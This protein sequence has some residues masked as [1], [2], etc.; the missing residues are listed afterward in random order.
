MSWVDLF[1]KRDPSATP[2]EEPACGLYF[3]SYD[4]T[5]LMTRLRSLVSEDHTPALR[6]R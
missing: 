3:A 6:S 4:K 2:N 5:L 1:R